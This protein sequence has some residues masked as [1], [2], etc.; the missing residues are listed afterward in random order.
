MLKGA[1]C[2]AICVDNVYPEEFRT[3]WLTC[4]STVK[5]W[6]KQNNLDYHF[7][8]KPINDFDPSSLLE[9]NHATRDTKTRNGQ[10]YKWQWVNSLC[11]DYDFIIW[12][13]ADVY[14]W[15]NPLIPKNPI[16]ES[17][18][19]DKLNCMQD[20]IE[21]VWDRPDLSIFWS[22]STVLR[23]IHNWY[24]EMLND[25]S[26]RD[27]LFTTLVTLSKHGVLKDFTEEVAL[28]PWVYANRSRSILHHYTTESK[29]TNNQWAFSGEILF[30]IVKPDSFLHFGGTRKQRMLQ[31]FQAYK[32]Y[33]SYIAKG[34]L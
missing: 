23:E 26:K 2:Q 27:D 29:P 16:Y 10:F 28:I 20:S 13:D 14:V 18:G 33:L 21:L 22:S 1:V 15:G 32:A 17:D 19:L 7:F 34:N 9:V 30:D 8:D 3:F 24:E 4:M 11:D 25:R 5:R 6:A 31:R 12:V